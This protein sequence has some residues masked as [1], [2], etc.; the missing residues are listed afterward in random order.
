ML[1]RCAGVHPDGRVVAAVQAGERLDPGLSVDELECLFASVVAHVAIEVERLLDGR[2]DGRL[3][4]EEGVVGRH[5]MPR[6]THPLRLFGKRYRE[7][8]AVGPKFVAH[9]QRVEQSHPVG[10]GR[11]DHRPHPR[12]HEAAIQP[13]MDVRQMRH[14]RKAP[15]ALRVRLHDGP[16][17]RHTAS[18]DRHHVIAVDQLAVRRVGGLVCDLRLIDAGGQHVDQVDVVHEL[19]MLLSSRAARHEDAQVPDA[20]VRRIDDGL[21]VAEHFRVVAVHVGHEAERLRRRCDVV[22]IGA[23]HDDGRADIAQV[24]PHAVARD[25]LGAG[26]PVAD[27]QVVD[28]VLHLLRIQEDVSAP[29]LLEAEIARRFGVDVGVKVILLAPQRIGR[30]EV[31]EVLHEPRAVET[32]VAEVAREGR[33]PAAA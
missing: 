24:E 10:G 25:Q 19:A 18:L 11:R 8:I 16:D 9:P 12:L 2:R 14:R 5:R 3:Q 21:V 32:P 28:D 15:V 30:I 7:R 22:A 4:R 1:G 20:L 13:E 31:L 27:E 6:F 23:E 33:E 26:E 29:V 17:V